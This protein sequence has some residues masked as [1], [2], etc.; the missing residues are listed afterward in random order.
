MGKNLHSSKI[1]IFQQKQIL[2]ALN[3]KKQRFEYLVLK[4]SLKPQISATGTGTVNYYTYQTVLECGIAHVLT[5]W[6]FSLERILRCLDRIKSEF[7]SFFDPEPYDHSKKIGKYT[8]SDQEID[9]EPLPSLT[10]ERSLKYHD[11]LILFSGILSYDREIKDPNKFQYY[12]DDLIDTYENI[13]K[14]VKKSDR[15]D[16]FLYEKGCLILD[17]TE[18]KSKIT[19]RLYLNKDLEFIS[20]DTQ[21]K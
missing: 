5:K 9:V 21:A 2:L 14:N 7:K 4:L 16:S 13:I 3:I 18:L 15:L 6:G 12:H 10:E 1:P 8:G 19:E 17:L 20:T 11:H